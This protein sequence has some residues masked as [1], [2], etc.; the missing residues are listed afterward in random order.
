MLALGLILLGFIT[1]RLPATTSSF[2]LYLIFY[3]RP[4]VGTAAILLGL[5]GGMQGRGAVA[6]GLG[7]FLLI[8]WVFGLAGI[9]FQAVP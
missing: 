3:S 8:T 2:V 5:T 7:A 4:V 9:A 6:I 1:P